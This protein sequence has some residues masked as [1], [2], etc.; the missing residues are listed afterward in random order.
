MNKL[1]SHA[2]WTPLKPARAIMPK[3]TGALPA[4][5]PCPGLP[6]LSE[7]FAQTAADAAAMGFV[8]STLTQQDAPVLWIQ[9]RLSRQEAG[10]PYLA[11]LNGMALMEVKA[12]RA[13][14]VLW[15]M[16][17]GLACRA[18]AAVVGE[19]WG[20]PARL[21]FTASKR[22]ALRAARY[23]V[24][25]WLIRRAASPDLSAARNRWRVAS[26][27][28]TSHPHDPK[29][30][31]DPRWQLTLFRSR[32]APPG[33]WTATHDRAANRVDFAAAIC[34]GALAEAENPREHSTAR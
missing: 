21:D 25:C 20:N 17:E 15:A 4:P 7:V 1:E 22:L 34:D 10:Q 24:S 28:A 19:I 29:A 16:E 23:G 14:D 3:R 8:L 32:D 27:P 26:L 5:S 11:G 9:D 30:P 33:T 6:G 18:L 2:P 31:G 13:V 12:S